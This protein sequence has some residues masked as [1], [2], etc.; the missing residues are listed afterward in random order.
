MKVADTS[1]FLASKES[2]DLIRKKDLS[3]R[4]F[5][6]QLFD[7]WPKEEL[8]VKTWKVLLGGK[9]KDLHL[10]DENNIFIIF[11][12]AMRAN[13]EVKFVGQHG[14]LVGADACWG[15][16]PVEYITVSSA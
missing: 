12:L 9:F 5:F 10:V 15:V 11:V 13:L 6:Y 7:I 1:L 3:F 8:S 16:D 2:Q 4:G 14:R